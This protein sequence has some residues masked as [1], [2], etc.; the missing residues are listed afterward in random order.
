M[1]DHVGVIDR[2]ARDRA[3]RALEI[4]MRVEEPRRIEENHLHVVSS[5]DPYDTVPRRLRFW[6]DDTELLSY[7]SIEQRR[8]AGIRLSD[9]C[10][11]ARACHWQKGVQGKC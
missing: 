4:V 2:R 7:E 5:E 9:E 10:D 6:T 11:H 1:K 3:H 8:F